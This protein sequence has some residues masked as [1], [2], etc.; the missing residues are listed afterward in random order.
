MKSPA[1]LGESVPT[2]SCSMNGTLGDLTDRTA[3]PLGS[4]HGRR[5]GGP[6]R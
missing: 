4:A 2:T 5:P 6:A 3:P 1:R